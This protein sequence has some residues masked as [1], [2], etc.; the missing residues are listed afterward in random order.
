METTY[1]VDSLFPMFSCLCF[2]SYLTVLGICSLCLY[3]V[4]SEYCRLYCMTVNIQ[5]WFFGEASLA[6]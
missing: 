4:F 1:N 5:A 2:A 3:C 6:S